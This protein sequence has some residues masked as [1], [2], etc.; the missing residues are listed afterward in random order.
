MFSRRPHSSRAFCAASRSISALLSSPPGP[1]AAPSSTSAAASR[2]EEVAKS[3]GALRGE[4][5][6]PARGEDGSSAMRCS[7]FVERLRRS[8]APAEPVELEGRS[9]AAAPRPEAPPPTPWPAPPR[10][11]RPRRLGE[12]CGADE[13]QLNEGLS[14]GRE[15]MSERNTFRSSRPS[16]GFRLQC[17]A[18]PPAPPAPS[19]DVPPPMESQSA[20]PLVLASR[21]SATFRASVVPRKTS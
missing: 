13:E 10:S 15:R 12:R 6:S 17:P 8:R 5:P 21:P 18:G 4:P 9:V 1:A 11:P 20:S 7:C 2:G 3:A 14:V 16:W 19:A